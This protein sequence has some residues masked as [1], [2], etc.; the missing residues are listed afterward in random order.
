[1]DAVLWLEQTQPGRFARHVISTDD[2]IHAAIAVGDIDTDGDVDILAGG[3][4]DYP[5]AQAPAVILFVNDG[6]V[7]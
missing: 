4:Y 2:P 3:F 5:R 1:M 7:P 6:Q